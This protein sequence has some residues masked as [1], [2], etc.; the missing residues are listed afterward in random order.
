MTTF[1]HTHGL[2]SLL[3]CTLLAS[4][5]AVTGCGGR[6]ATVPDSDEAIQNWHR[7]RDYQAQG[8]YELAREHYL[9]AI[10]SARTAD[11]HDALARELATVDRQLRSLR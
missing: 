8:R 6:V 10:A 4:A 11:V 1:R 5:L 2:R 7:G 3:I 9:L